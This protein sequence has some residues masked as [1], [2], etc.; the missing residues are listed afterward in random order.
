MKF[1]VCLQA[2][3]VADQ[4]RWWRQE[5]RE[6]TELTTNGFPSQRCATLQPVGKPPQGSGRIR[7]VLTLTEEGK[8]LF[9]R[10][11]TSDPDTS[12]HLDYLQQTGHC[13]FITEFSFSFDTLA[14]TCTSFSSPQVASWFTDCCFPTS[15]SPRS[16]SPP[17]AIAPTV[18]A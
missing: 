12:H 13:I 11:P 5:P 3:R 7:L 15:S 14:K 2:R 10:P 17:L 8:S 16:S 9:Q 1:I 6:R 4:R 18:G